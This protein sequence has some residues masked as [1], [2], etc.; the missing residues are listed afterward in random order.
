MLRSPGRPPAEV[1]DLVESDTEETSSTATGDH[2]A[3]DDVSEEEIILEEPI[4]TKQSPRKIVSEGES[5][6]KL[7]QERLQLA[8]QDNRRSSQ[9]NSLSPERAVTP[10][11]VL[12]PD[13]DPP[14]MSDGPTLHKV[15]ST[16]VDRQTHT[17]ECLAVSVSVSPKTVMFYK[18]REA[19]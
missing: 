17:E 6:T 5:R 15:I 11:P 1:V 2:E 10:I 16:I 9:I 12:V 3:G 19:F 13:E 7:F 4:K 14:N 18:H 8:Q